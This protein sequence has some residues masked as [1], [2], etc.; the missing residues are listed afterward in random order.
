M[1]MKE[2]QSRRRFVRNISVGAGA[3]AVFRGVGLIGAQISGQNQI[4]AIFVDFDKCTGCRTCE[5]VCSSVQNRVEIDGQRLRGLGNPEKS[6]I[7]VWHY[8]PDV[9]VPVTC[10]LCS[11]VPCIQACPVGPAPGTGRKAIYR[12]PELGTIKVD[13]ERCIACGA[14]AEVCASTRGGVI[15]RNAETGKPERICTL[16]G[17][18]TACVR[19]CPYGALSYQEIT[20]DDELRNM[21]PDTIAVRLIEK[22]YEMQLET[23]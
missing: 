1:A 19:N 23:I 13:Y 17:G 7:R 21:T 6:N 22:Y 3:I 15:A 18:R 10:F 20:M 5:T 11:D 14:C 9:D 4:K 16:C 8:N 12:D 2:L